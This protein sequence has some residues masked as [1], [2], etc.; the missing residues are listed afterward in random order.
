M[1]NNHTKEELELI[2]FKDFVR[3][4]AI[5]REKNWWLDIKLSFV[6][7]CRWKKMNGYR[8]EN[9]KDMREAKKLLAKNYSAIQYFKGEYALLNPLSEVERN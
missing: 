5:Q 6:S 8:M 4:I 7:Y 1:K 9:D 2:A 3:D